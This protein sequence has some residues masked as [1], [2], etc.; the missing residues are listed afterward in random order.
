MNPY[1]SAFKNL[2][3]T[4][5]NLETVLPSEEVDPDGNLFKESFADLDT[6]C[7]FPETL[8]VYFQNNTNKDFFILRLNIRS[9]KKY[10]DD[11]KRFI[12]QLN[13]TFKVIRLSETWLHYAKHT[14]SFILSLPND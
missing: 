7:F 6:K 14:A 9:L 11:F 3:F 10:F 2:A 12:S 1:K 8:P 13:F 5:G 4:L